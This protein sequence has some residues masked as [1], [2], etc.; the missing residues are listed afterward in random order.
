MLVNEDGPF[1]VFAWI[2][3]RLGVET[4][5]EISGIATLL[6]CVWCTSVWTAALLWPLWVTA[7][8]IPSILAASTVA[9]AIDT[10]INRWNEQG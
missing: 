10:A 4:P 7:P 9:I 2:R 6:T 5:G 3:R 1:A 8:V